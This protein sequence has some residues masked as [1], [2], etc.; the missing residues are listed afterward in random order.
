MMLIRFAVMLT[1]RNGG[2]A[3]IDNNRRAVYGYDQRVEV[4]WLRRDGV[5]G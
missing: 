3:L 5:C 2:Y 4:F 1:F